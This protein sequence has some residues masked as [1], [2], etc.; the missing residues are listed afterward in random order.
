MTL[1]SCD[2]DEV[3]N[4]EELKLKLNN[5]L[6]E[7]SNV[8]NYVKEIEDPV[9]NL[10]LEEHHMEASEFSD[11]EEFANGRVAADLLLVYG[12]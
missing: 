5:I 8:T 6:R 4:V 10:R 1:F 12:S 9:R 7:N 3:D 11:R 2:Q